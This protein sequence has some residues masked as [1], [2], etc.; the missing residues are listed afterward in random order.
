M[1][2][3]IREGTNQLGY[4]LLMLSE[5]AFNEH[6]NSSLEGKILGK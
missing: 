5:N 6:V 1:I 2:G 3:M 4:Y